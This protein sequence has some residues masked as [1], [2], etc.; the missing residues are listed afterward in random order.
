MKDTIPPR[1]SVL[2]VD[3]GYSLSNRSSGVCRLTW[4]E[5]QVEWTIRRFKYEPREREQVVK[6]VI[7]DHPILATAFDGPLRGSLD[8][9]GRY[10][11]AERMLTRRLQPLIGKPAQAS[12]PGGKQLNA[13]ANEAA[14]LV[15]SL[16]NLGPARHAKAI[17]K[18]AIV[19]AFPTSYLGVLID[20]P[21]ALGQGRAGKSDR[22][23]EKLAVDGTLDHLLRYF[24]PDR[25]TPEFTSVTNHDDRAALVC[26]LTALGV[27]ADDF[28][29]TGDEDG[30]IILPPWSLTSPWAR[31]M[32]E[33]NSADQMN[34]GL[35][36]SA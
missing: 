5:S 33:A 16:G 23:Y 7:S 26:A 22:F 18:S 34:Q 30:W 6:A 2:G 20:D 3:V 15:L 11:L 14:K 17:H 24:L 35:Y 4:T 32:L 31:R 28:S 9:I 10:R 36:K 8:V 21:G 12:T 27:L 25:R 19:E 29:A 1:G 13:A